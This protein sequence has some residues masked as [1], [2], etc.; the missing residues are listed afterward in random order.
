MIF[1]HVSARRV[2]RQAR[3]TLGRRRAPQPGTT[4]AT[5][6]QR[7]SSSALAGLLPLRAGPAARASVCDAGAL[8]SL[9]P[10]SR[11]TGLNPESPLWP[12]VGPAAALALKFGAGS[13]MVGARRVLV[14]WPSCSSVCRRHILKI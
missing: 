3:R 12:S 10:L 4:P 8:P 1:C 2:V 14:T 5:R 9:Q 6:L 7:P 11:G 13:V